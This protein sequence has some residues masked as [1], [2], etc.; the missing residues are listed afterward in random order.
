MNTQTKNQEE[1]IGDKLDTEIL[2]LIYED[3]LD[4]SFDK[5]I[6]KPYSIVYIFNQEEEKKEKEEEE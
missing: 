4:W 2:D 5:P 3:G 6:N 1:N